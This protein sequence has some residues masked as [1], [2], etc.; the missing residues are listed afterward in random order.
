MNKKE[1][2]PKETRPHILQLIEADKKCENANLLRIPNRFQTFGECIKTLRE[3]IGWSQLQ[4]EEK[5]QIKGLKVAELEENKWEI[6]DND[7]DIL[8]IM[9]TLMNYSV[10]PSFNVKRL[11][12]VPVGNGEGWNFLAL[13]SSMRIFQTFYEVLKEKEIDIKQLIGY[14]KNTT[15]TEEK[16]MTTEFGEYLK[17]LRKKYQMSQEEIAHKA[18]AYLGLIINI[19]EEIDIT[20]DKYI[21]LELST[22][23]NIVEAFKYNK[24]GL[25]TCLETVKFYRLAISHYYIVHE[26][27]HNRIMKL[28]EDE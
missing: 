1:N 8:K 27:Q 19:E 3:N 6:P 28:M 10:C 12:G 17:T 25:L 15:K 13:A 11:I 14:L 20:K 23:D 16:R 9:K 26:I 5:L 18:N 7:D 22:L 2:V 24:V 21:L 4:L